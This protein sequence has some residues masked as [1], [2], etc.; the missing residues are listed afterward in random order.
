[1]YQCGVS[2]DMNYG[3][4][5][6]GAQSND[7]ET[8]MRMHFGYS[9]AMYKERSSYQDDAWIALLKSELDESRPMYFSGTSDIGSHAIVCDGYDNNDYFH[10]NMGWSGASDGFY[11]I[12]DVNGFNRNEAIV[13]NI[14]PLSINSDENGIIYVA[15]DG[16]GDGSSWENATPYL[17]YAA[18]IGSDGETQIWVKKGTYYG[19][20]NGENG[21]FYIYQ[22]N[23]VYGGLVGNEPADYNLDNR[24]LENNVTILDGGNTRRVLY[25]YDHFGSTAYSI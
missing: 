18:S 4:D 19:D 2:V 25:Q 3:Y 7:V 14:R 16:T 5:G 20:A 12:D 24:D 1:M 13:M 10:F 9:S 17:E 8:A 23:R 22:K 6:S 11:S 21:A 15:S